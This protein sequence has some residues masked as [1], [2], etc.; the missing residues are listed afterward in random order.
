MP[1]LSLT[2]VIERQYELLKRIHNT[3][4]NIKKVGKDNPNQELLEARLQTREKNWKEFQEN[5]TIILSQKFESTQ[6]SEY[7]VNDCYGVTEEGYI[8]SADYI[9]RLLRGFPQQNTPPIVQQTV[10][11]RKLPNIEVP[12]FSGK[13]IDWLDFKDLFKA[14]IANDERLSNLEKLQQLK[15]HV[16]GEAAD[17]LKTI[18]ITDLNVHI[19]FATTL[20]AS[21][22]EQIL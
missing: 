19:S 21:G 6:K 9:A 14:T 17:M 22:W 12:T 15:T 5:H 1:T 8:N 20:L 3:P 2:Q 18:Q 4:E 7:F 13:F 16:Q 10:P 11:T